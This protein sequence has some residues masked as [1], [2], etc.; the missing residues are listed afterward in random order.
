MYN[1]LVVDDS[2]LMRKLMCDIINSNQGFS[3]KDVC[4]DGDAAL[5]KMR[6]SKYD[7]VTLNMF[8]PRMNGIEFLQRMR[9]EGLT[10]PIIAIS[11]SVKEDRELTVTALENGAAEVV[12][13][14][15][16][17]IGPDK[18]TF[19][20]SLSTALKAAVAQGARTVRTPITPTPVPAPT[21][22]NTDKFRELAS[23]APSK[24]GNIKYGLVAIASS[25]GGPQALH[26][27]I[28]MLPAHLGVPVVLVQ[29]MPMGFTA[30][31][32]ERIDSKAKVHVKEAEDGEELMPDTVYIAPGGRHLEILES[33]GKLTARVFDDPPVFNLR[34]CADVTFRSLKNISIQ[35]ILCVVMTGMG[36][37]GT[38]GLKFL[39]MYKHLYVITQSE[40]TCV[41]YGMPKAADNAKL[42]N[43]SVPLT[44]IAHAI[45]KELG[46]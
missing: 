21:P 8:L 18:E 36:A 19:S 23:S 42:S 5:S 35:N 22:V 44:G 46:G 10:V 12:L 39:K 27:M 32:A 28:P 37:D 15:Y 33:H 30:S 2:A 7:A 20:R 24:R 11:T 6:S 40:D 31:L 13:R 1:I 29:H 14:P 43:E 17:L 16:R 3:A 45:A 26:T 34:P 25:T 9:T 41:V 38:E 4:T